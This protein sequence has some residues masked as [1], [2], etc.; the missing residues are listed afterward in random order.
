MIHLGPKVTHIF[1]Y[2]ISSVYL[3][4]NFMINQIS[5]FQL[6]LFIS[7]VNTR[8]FRQTAQENNTT[9]SN[10]TK[11][12]KVLEERIGCPL[13][14]RSRVLLELTPAGS[15]FLPI[16]QNTVTNLYDGIH[17]I[18]KQLTCHKLLKIG[19]APLYMSNAL[20]AGN[21]FANKFPDLNL[22]IKQ[23]VWS[24]LV[25][26]YINQQ[27]DIIIGPIDALDK[28][29]DAELS[30][31]PKRKNTFYCRSE[32]PILK[33]DSITAEHIDCYPIINAASPLY[34]RTAL[35]NFMKW[36]VPY[37]EKCHLF[38]ESVVD[39][40]EQVSSSDAISLAP[41]VLISE[42]IKLGKIQAFKTTPE[43]TLNSKSAIAV[44]KSKLNDEAVNWLVKEILY[45]EQKAS[46]EDF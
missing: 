14:I 27:L 35:Q 31:L 29:K 17:K 38:S 16:A 32:H 43:L 28:L 20:K 13:I 8:S 33:H 25:S 42:A 2:V 19:A 24:D 40:I 26:T 39:I 46:E 5:I 4:K 18:N 41:T 36:S 7:I 30:V 37:E 45:W 12:I 34:V 3:Y 11:S 22:E 9:P 15:L 21:T 10:V 44:R 23:R 1:A 6:Q